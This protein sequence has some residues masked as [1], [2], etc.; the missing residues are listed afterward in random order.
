MKKIIST[1][2]FS[3][4]IISA[5]S[6]ATYYWTG[7]LNASWLGANSWN[8]TLGG[9]G[10]ARTAPNVT[11]IL[12][13]DGSNIGAGATGNIGVTLIQ[14]ETIASLRIQNG[15]T[16]SFNSGIAGTSLSANISR[17]A[18]VLYGP[19]GNTTAVLS[20][21]VGMT[22][23]A[24]ILPGAIITVASASS[25]PQAIS[26]VTNVV[27]N[28]SITLTQT[29]STTTSG[30]ASITIS[31][32]LNFSASPAVA[33]NVG[34]FVYTGTTSN[35]EQITS[36]VD[37]AN[38][39]TTTGTA[40]IAAAA[41]FKA[42]PLVLTSTTKAL[43][44]ASG[45]QLTI[46][47]TTAFIL[48]LAAGAVG[49][50]DGTII[51]SSGSGTTRIIVDADGT[52]SLTFKNGSTLDGGAVSSIFGA[53]ANINNNNVI[54]Q[55]GSQVIY[56]ASVGTNGIF[57][58]MYP[59]S[60]IKFQKGSTFAWNGSATG[61]SNGTN[62]ELPNVKINVS[63]SSFGPQVIDTLTIPLGISVSTGSGNSMLL[64][65]DFI[66][67]GTFNF[68]ATNNGLNFIFAGSVPQRI[69]LRGA[70]GGGSTTYNLATPP[71]SGGCFQKFVVAA[72]S[73]L[74]LHPS[75]DTLR[76]YAAASIYGTLNF[77]SNIIKNTS[78]NFANFFSPKP[79]N[80]PVGSTT[81]VVDVNNSYNIVVNGSLTTFLPGMIL[82][83][84]GVPANTVIA[85]TATGNIIY[86]SNPVTLAAGATVTSSVNPIGATITT[87][88]TGGLGASYTTPG[89]SAAYAMT[90]PGANY[91]FDGATTT[92]FPS[93]ITTVQTNN[94]TLAADI[95]SNVNNLNI[96]GTL[97][98]GGNTLTVPVA[99][100]VRILSGNAIAG[101]S[102]TKF[103]SLGVNAATGGKGFLRIGNIAATT[104]FPIG[105]NGNY[106]PVTIT[107]AAASEDYTVSVFNGI[108]A[109]GTPNGTPFTTTQKAKV[110]DAVWTLNNNFTPTG[111]A[112]IQVGWPTTL[113]GSNFAGFTNQIGIALYNTTWGSPTGTGNNSAN[114]A[115]AS[116]NTFGTFGVGQL[117]AAL[118]VKFSSIVASLV[119]NNQIKI[120]WQTATEIN[121][122]KYF[123]EA[124][125]NGILFSEKGAVTASN[126]IVYNF[127]D[128]SPAQGL[129]F[130]R[131][132]AIDKDGTVT[133][134]N[135][136]L[137][138][139][140]NIA[141]ALVQVYP[142][143][144]TNNTLNINFSNIQS[145][146]YSLT[147]VNNIG[148]VILN[149]NINLNT[150]SSFVYSVVLPN[151]ILPGLY[152][153]KIKGTAAQFVNDIIIKQ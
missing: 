17:V 86:L 148:Q 119:K 15:A 54:F 75:N 1:V 45:C 83:G 50:V 52:A 115:T 69:L 99:D 19:T 112:T 42:N 138:S 78:T 35:I 131:I 139:S 40:A 36:T 116:Y 126:D 91:R 33:L 104:L 98:L 26:V 140:S 127:V 28:T 105:S 79:L 130:Y 96:N 134:S 64:K 57:G 4:F 29:A 97:D 48:K 59:A 147:I 122:D 8:T 146:D 37:G 34:D 9:G 49:T 5:F 70:S 108:T 39:F 46:N 82:N 152:H 92:P 84:P 81:L 133:I 125:T 13:F 124:S 135:T 58:A 68:S 113:K 60:V 14:P 120:I 30:T 71:A 88:N 61:F 141:T 62:R 149:K 41:G 3:F 12:I 101:S 21:I 73:T 90:S 63:I 24:G 76:T 16:V 107:P 137:V 142:N 11:D 53:V 102:A 117:G 55:S 129:N 93:T 132:K 80:T 74:T 95:S 153:L 47:S 100:T 110:I 20:N 87:A 56:R 18:P 123:I 114:T 10:T 2:L 23:T 22:S 44:V 151:A 144:V 38:V 43:S 106:L 121:V 32:P 103:I 145:G 109:D 136:V 66:N 7:G 25:L 85:N 31:Q 143:P 6:Q 94:L 118:P 27:A 89:A 72:N 77:G 65:G 111:N 67:E 150:S 128:V 51:S